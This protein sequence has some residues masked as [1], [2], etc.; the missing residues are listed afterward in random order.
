MLNWTICFQTVTPESAEQGDFDSHGFIDQY[1]FKYDCDQC[2]KDDDFPNHT[3]SISE[4]IND[5][6]KYG[7]NADE[8]ADWLYS[9]DPDVDYQTGED[10]TYSLHIEGVSPF[11]QSRI[12]QLVTN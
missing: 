4:L 5:C 12:H 2:V 9:V 7:I 10:T 3:G 8:G 1:G 6:H 11:T